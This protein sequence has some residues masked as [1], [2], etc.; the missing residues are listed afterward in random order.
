[1]KK[2]VFVTAMLFS[3]L[4]V[5]V[6]FTNVYVSVANKSDSEKEKETMTIVT[7][8]NPMYMAVL[9]ITADVE[10]VEV[11][12]FSQPT[13]GCLHDYTLTPADMKAL[14]KADAFVVNGAGMEGFLQNVIEAYPDLPIIDASMGVS[15]NDMIEDNSH[16]W[17][18]PVCYVQQ[19]KYIAVELG[20]RDFNRKSEYITNADD[21]IQNI[22]YSLL[23]TISGDAFETSDKNVVI[24][25][26]AF[27]YLAKDLGLDIVAVMDLDEERQVSAGE[28]A[29]IVD[30]MKETGTSKI[31]SDNE[32]AKTMSQTISNELLKASGQKAKTAY[33]DTMVKGTYEKDDYIKV[34]DSNIQQIYNMIY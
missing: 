4:L 32:Y 12:N 1:M 7:S 26:E 5:A 27:E 29:E 15:E 20:E 24:L 17:M 22:E 10:G 6:V 9:N 34:M 8:C 33:I 19:C 30:I 11:C 31:V 3:I 13:T 14:A 21:Y 28:V 18:S 2:N 25:Q 23:R 16:L